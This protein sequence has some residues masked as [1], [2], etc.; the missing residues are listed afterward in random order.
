MTNGL[1]VNVPV[2]PAA[3]VVIHTL[4]ADSTSGLAFLDVISLT[5]QNSDD[6]PQNVNVLFTPVGG[7]SITQTYTLAGGELR[8]VIDEDAFGGPLS[9]LGGG[10]ISL[11]NASQVVAGPVR[12][13]GWFVRTRG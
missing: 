12:A 5:L 13:W 2:A 9:G 6:S 8:E 3:P 7:P 1:P 11:L 4:P 10:T